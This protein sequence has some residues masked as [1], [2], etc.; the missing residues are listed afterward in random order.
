MK[1]QIIITPSG[2]RMVVLAEPDYEALVRAAAAAGVEI[3]DDAPPYHPR[4]SPRPS[5]GENPIR[6]WRERRG[7]SLTLLADRTKLLE[8][9][10]AELETGAR[11]PTVEVLKVLAKALGVSIDEL[12]G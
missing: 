1:K 6:F 10:L 11:E 2:E 9:D 3:E 8:D 4:R 5:E 12:V 7:M